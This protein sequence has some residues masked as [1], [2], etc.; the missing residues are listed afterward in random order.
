LNSANRANVVDVASYY[1]RVQ[2]EQTQVCGVVVIENVADVGLM[3]AWNIDHKV[4]K[5][6][7]SLI[8]VDVPTFVTWCH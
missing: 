4:V 6:W 1:R 7:M 2:D 5:L 8:Q 3:H